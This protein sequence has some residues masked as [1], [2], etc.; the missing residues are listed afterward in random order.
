MLPEKVNATKNE[1]IYKDNN[2]DVNEEIIKV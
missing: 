1:N 2:K